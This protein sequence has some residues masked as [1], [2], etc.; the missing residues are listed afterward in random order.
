MIESAELKHE[1]LWSDLYRGVACDGKVLMNRGQKG[2]GLRAGHGQ[3]KVHLTRDSVTA[4]RQWRSIDGDTA[5]VFG[6][7][8]LIVTT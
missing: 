2:S 8:D 4:A 1:L 6:T 5:G 3:N 7:T